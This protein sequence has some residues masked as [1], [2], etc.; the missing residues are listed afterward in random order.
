LFAYI[1]ASQD[2]YEVRKQFMA[3]LLTYKENECEANMPAGVRDFL[4]CIN[5]TQSYK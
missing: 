5:A 1:Y 3:Q 2:G 4:K